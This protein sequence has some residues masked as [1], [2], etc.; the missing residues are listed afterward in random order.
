M[1]F[2]FSDEQRQMRSAIERLC[3]PFDAGYWLQ[4]DQDGQFPHDFHQ[5][6]AGAGWLGVAMPA[7]FGGA[8]L[9]ITEAALMMQTF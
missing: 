8:G 1:D 7:A 3:A 9:G 5:A 6:L 4:R 2:G